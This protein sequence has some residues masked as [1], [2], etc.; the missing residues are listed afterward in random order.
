MPSDYIDN[1]VKTI[2]ES[3]LNEHIYPQIIDKD[4]LHSVDFKFINPFV[5]DFNKLEIEQIYDF[6]GAIRINQ[7]V[8][9]QIY[10]C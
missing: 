3:F 7:Y 6:Y 8:C 10:N 4:N 9:Q 1:K 5:K 2:T